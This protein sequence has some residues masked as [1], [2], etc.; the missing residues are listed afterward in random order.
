MIIRALHT[1]GYLDV[2]SVP[3]DN[4]SR[5]ISMVLSPGESRTVDDSYASLSGITNAVSRG[6]LE[7]VSYE[8][9]IPILVTSLPSSPT[10]YISYYLLQTDATSKAPPG[11]YIY[12][13]TGWTCSTGSIYNLGNLGATPTLNLISGVVYNWTV[14]VE[15][16]SATITLSTTGI[17]AFVNN[18]PSGNAWIEDNTSATGRII[19]DVEG[20]AFTN[21][22]ET[23][24]CIGTF[25]DDGTNL[26]ITAA[27]DA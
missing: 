4:V 21:L 9:T 24:G 1:N 13:G 15:I 11:T 12:N 2:S 6:L 22:A 7:I 18:N 8:N 26:W 20:S 27:K 19:K 17:V 14:N 25:K 3:A 16:T 10:N 23:A 5:Y